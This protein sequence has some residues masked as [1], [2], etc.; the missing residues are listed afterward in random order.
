MVRPKSVELALP[1]GS[2]AR[3]LRSKENRPLWSGVNTSRRTARIDELFTDGNGPGT[4]RE[5]AGKR[6]GKA[7]ASDDV[8][9]PS[10]M[11]IPNAPLCFSGTV[12]RSP[13]RL[14]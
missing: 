12:K 5:R 11:L 14:T 9:S 8:T 7:F 1:S 6:P 13:E 4:G 10:P 3:H 2:A